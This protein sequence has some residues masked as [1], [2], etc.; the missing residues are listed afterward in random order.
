MKK[1]FLLFIVFILECHGCLFAKQVYHPYILGQSASNWNLYWHDEFT[2][3]STIDNNWNAQNA[4]P[5]GLVSS[6]WRGNLVVSHHHLKILNKKEFKGGK[7][8]TSGSMTSKK[9]FK[10]GYFECK[11]KISKSSGVNNSFWLCYNNPTPN[12]GHQFEIDVIEGHFPNMDFSNIHD[13]GVA[14]NNQDKQNSKLYYVKPNLY[15]K[16][17]I[18]GLEWNPDSLKFY[19]DGKIVRVEKNTCCFDEAPII[20]GTAV[21]PWAGAITD[22]INNTSMSVDYVRVYHKR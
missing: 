22:K 13:N 18:F 4:S 10:Y 15:D 1:F 5:E 11:M 14:P 2:G 9:T 20:L 17:H 19:V 21:L 16:Y 6:R 7:E 8:W 12:V 3:N